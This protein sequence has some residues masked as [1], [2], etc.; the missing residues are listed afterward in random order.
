MTAHELKV[1]TLTSSTPNNEKDDE[2]SIPLCLDDLI[3]VCKEYTKLG[4]QVQSQVEN[5][6]EVGVEESIKSGVVQHVALSHIKSFLLS[7]NKNP[8]F[9]DASSQA[10]DCI[11]LIQRYEETNKININLFN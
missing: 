4:W 6:L 7:I 10:D 2:Y 3:N 9:G 5:I 11:K 8:Y 1:L